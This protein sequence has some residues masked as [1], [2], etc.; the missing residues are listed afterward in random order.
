MICFELID[1]RMLSALE[2]S[3][4]SPKMHPELDGPLRA[5]GFPLKS[6]CFSLQISRFQPISLSVIFG[7][8]VSKKR[9]MF[10]KSFPAPWVKK[11]LRAHG[12]NVSKTTSPF[13]NDVTLHPHPK[14]HA[15]GPYNLHKWSY[16]GPYKWP[17]KWV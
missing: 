10:N 14:S 3:E 17:S 12:R 2:V 13:K 15:D 1:H 4:V 16:R 11:L 7:G 6:Q 9:S 8:D 5:P